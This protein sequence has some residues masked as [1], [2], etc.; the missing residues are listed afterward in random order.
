LVLTTGDTNRNDA[1]TMD[2]MYAATYTRRGQRRN[3]VW[4]Y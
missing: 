3:K 1:A 4:Y 2:N